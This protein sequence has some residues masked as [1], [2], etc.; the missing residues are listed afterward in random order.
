MTDRTTGLQALRAIVRAW[1]RRNLRRNPH[2]HKPISIHDIE[3]AIA[4]LERA[5]E[6]STPSADGMKTSASQEAVGSAGGGALSAEIARLRAALEHVDRVFPPCAHG[7]G[8]RNVHDC[9]VCHVR[10]AL[11]GADGPEER[12]TTCGQPKR[13]EVTTCSNPFHRA[14]ETSAR[15]KHRGSPSYDRGETCLDCG[16]DMH[17]PIHAV[18]T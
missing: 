1:V 10:E 11:R 6:Q 13:I 4:E 8:P 18:K 12:C 9:Y 16:R 5:E 17:D 7:S 15:H 14:D 2:D 3:R